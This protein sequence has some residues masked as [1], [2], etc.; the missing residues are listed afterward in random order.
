MNKNLIPDK[1]IPSF[2]R[3]DIEDLRKRK[4]DTI[5]LDIDNTLVGYKCAEPTPKVKEWIKYLQ[6]EGFKIG[7]VSNANKNRTE[8]FCKD[9][10]VAY[11]HR[12]AKPG[13]G[14]IRKILALLGSNPEHTVFVGDQ[15]FTDMYGANKTGCY[16][17]LVK[18]VS[19]DE[20]LYCKFKRIFERMVHKKIRK[21]T[22]N[23]NPAHKNT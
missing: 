7:V 23:C 21:E 18:Q 17:V 4:I 5:L 16:S 11:V 8:V 15:I 13:A 1:M 14:G 3:L 22:V 6:A 10:G 9:L 20:S 12:A 2:D 19:K